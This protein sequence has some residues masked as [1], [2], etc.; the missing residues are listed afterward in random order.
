MWCS[1]ASSAR[2]SG[3]I[4]GSRGTTSGRSTSAG[5]GVGRWKWSEIAA[6][7]NEFIEKYGLKGSQAAAP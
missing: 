2:I 5:R 4:G 1:R 3:F 6:K 7:A